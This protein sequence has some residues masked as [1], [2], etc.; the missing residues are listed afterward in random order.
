MEPAAPGVDQTGAVAQPVQEATRLDYLHE[1]DH[2]AD[3]IERLERAIDAAAP[4]APPATRA[5]I[6]ALQALRGLAL[7]SA[8]TMVAKSVS[9]RGSLGRRRSWATA[10][11]GRARTSSGTRSRRG[12]RA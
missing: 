3:R 1:V 2:V 12:G 8:V 9:C 6:E 5:V 10:A 7:V 4:T 11:W